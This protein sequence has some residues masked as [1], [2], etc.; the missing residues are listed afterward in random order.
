MQYLNHRCSGPDV[1]GLLVA[2]AQSQSDVEVARSALWCLTNIAASDV[3]K[4]VASVMQ[5]VPCLLA[6]I[7]LGILSLDIVEVNNF[8][9]FLS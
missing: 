9:F 6:V 7:N 1:I 8:V 5:A 4:H 2:A 3:E